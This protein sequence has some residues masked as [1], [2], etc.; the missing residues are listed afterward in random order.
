MRV[1]TIAA[2][3]VSAALA[4][5][6]LAQAQPNRHRID[7]SLAP[8]KV[9]S[10]SFGTVPQGEFAFS[11]RAASDGDKRLIL[12]QQRDTSPTSFRVLTLPSPQAAERVPGRG[13]LGRLPGHH[14][15]GHARRSRLALQGEEPE[16]AADDDLP[17][18]RLEARPQRGLM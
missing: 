6:A 14:D 16:P 8:G 15:A 4:L 13:R 7:A 17:H 2:V 3:A 1:R 11:L 10:L 18:H 12:T 9:L 5:P